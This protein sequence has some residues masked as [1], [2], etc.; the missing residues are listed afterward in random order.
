MITSNETRTP[1]EPNPFGKGLKPNADQWLEVIGTLRQTD[2]EAF[3]AWLSESLVC[4]EASLE[5][6]S[7]PKSR[8]EVRS[9]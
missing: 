4:L 2:M 9:R 7:S 3:G 8:G 6:F 1:S 5:H